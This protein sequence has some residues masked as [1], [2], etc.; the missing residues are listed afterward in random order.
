MVHRVG[1]FLSRHSMPNSELSGD[2]GPIPTSS[3]PYREVIDRARKMIGGD[4]TLRVGQVAATGSMR[5]YLGESAL[6]IMET[7]SRDRLREGSLISFVRGGAEYLHILVSLTPEGAVTRGANPD[8]R[9][10]VPY[11]AITGVNVATLYFDPTTAPRDRSGPP[12]FLVASG[13]QVPASAGSLRIVDA[14]MVSGTNVALV[15]PGS[16]GEYSVTL[17]RDDTLGLTVGVPGAASIP[18][19][20]ANI[21]WSPANAGKTVRFQVYYPNAPETGVILVDATFLR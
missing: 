3:R 8:T 20:E 2:A 6:V 13:D 17:Q 12:I 9:E 10:V 1:G 15:Y 19:A 18:T 5:P 14:A 4:P 21:A 7:T 11:S 16:P